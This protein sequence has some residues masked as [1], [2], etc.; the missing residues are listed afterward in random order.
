M[1]ELFL[2]Q[3]GP[4]AVA[5]PTDDFGY[6]LLVTFKNE[7]GG[8]NTFGVEVKGTESQVPKSLVV[9]SHLRKSLNF[10]NLPTFL[11][12]ADVKRNKLFYGWPEHPERRISLH[13]L[14]AHG[15]SELR[16]RLLDLS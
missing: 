13:E 6:D 10:S 11:L 14:D 3:L 16:K 7:K 8:I 5:R 15:T 4:V 1:A 2:Q 9:D 12:F